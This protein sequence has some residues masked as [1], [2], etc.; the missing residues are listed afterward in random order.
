LGDLGDIKNIRKC[1]FMDLSEGWGRLRLYQGQIRNSNKTI[2]I[3]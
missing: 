1:S 2:K 3:E